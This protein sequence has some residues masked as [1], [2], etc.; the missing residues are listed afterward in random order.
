MP[1][2]LNRIAKSDGTIEMDW[3]VLARLPDTVQVAPTEPLMYLRWGSEVE[4][5]DPARAAR[6]QTEEGSECA[7]QC[8]PGST[9]G[10]RVCE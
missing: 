9:V 2:E 10:Q 8:L 3:E 5:R 4:R 7:V 1:G 6:R